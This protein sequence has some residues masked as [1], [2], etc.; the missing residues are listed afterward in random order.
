MVSGHSSR[1][2]GLDKP[3]GHLHAPVGRVRHARV[4]HGQSHQQRAR[5]GDDADHLLHLA[6]LGGRRAEHDG[7][8]LDQLQPRPQC[9]RVGRVHAERQ[10]G[11]LL[12]H[13]QGPLQVLQLAGRIT[14]RVDVQEVGPGLGLTAGFV[15]DMLRVAFGQSA[16]DGGAGGVDPLAD[17]QHG[18]S[19]HRALA[20]GSISIRTEPVNRPPGR[21]GCGSR[22][23]VVRYRMARFD[24]ERAVRGT[25]AGRA[26]RGASGAL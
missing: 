6:F 13:L 17:D 10:V 24:S 20:Q 2:G 1:L 14:A 15:G 4:V 21:L 12:H 18:G 23:A 22:R 19:H 7:L 25:S 26:K 16:G 8:A 11:G 9:L 3:G 5:V